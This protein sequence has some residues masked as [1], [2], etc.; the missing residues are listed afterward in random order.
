MRRSLI[1]VLM[2]ADVLFLIWTGYKIVAMIIPW[3]AVNSKIIG[4]IIVF[5]TLI[6]LISDS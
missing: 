1:D 5:A 2:V 4:G 3:V 6:S